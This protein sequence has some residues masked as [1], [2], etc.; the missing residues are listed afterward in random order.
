MVESSE[1]PAPQWE[2]QMPKQKPRIVQAYSVSRGASLRPW[3]WQ[4][5]RRQRGE[6]SE[7]GPQKWVQGIESG[8]AASKSLSRINSGPCSNYSKG[9]QEV[10]KQVAHQCGKQGAL[11]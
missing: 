7:K 10:E 1:F 8:E 5:E 9:T 4:R 6:A 11:L 3:H 2:R